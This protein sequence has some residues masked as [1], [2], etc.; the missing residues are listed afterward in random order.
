MSTPDT[1]TVLDE[2]REIGKKHLRSSDHGVQ[3]S[4]AGGEKWT[5]ETVLDLIDAGIDPDTATDKE[6]IRAIEE[7]SNLIAVEGNG[8]RG[9]ILTL[10][11]GERILEFNTLG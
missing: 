6:I 1:K 2:E 5:L 8:V 10:V 3:F 4:I 9:K 11:H 7:S